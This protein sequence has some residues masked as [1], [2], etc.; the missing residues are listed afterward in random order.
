TSVFSIPL[1]LATLPQKSEER[2]F[3]YM[4]VIGI[5]ED[6]LRFGETRS[7]EHLITLLQSRNYDQVSSP[8]RRSLF[9]SSARKRKT[10]QS[11]TRNTLPESEKAAPVRR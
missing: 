11:G 3:R 9:Q 10:S 7:P 8:T 2:P 4:N 1:R 5:T 6:E